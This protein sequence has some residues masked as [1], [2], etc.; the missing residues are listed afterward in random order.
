MFNLSPR[1]HDNCCSLG[2]G[3]DIQTYFKSGSLHYHYSDVIMSAIASEITSVAIVCATHKG[4]VT[5]K[6]FPFDDVIM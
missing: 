4:P 3:L 6:M 2:W 5:R 1:T